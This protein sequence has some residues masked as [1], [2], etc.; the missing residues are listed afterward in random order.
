[1]S[2][3]ETLEFEFTPADACGFIPVKLS[4]S[5]GAVLQCYPRLALPF[6]PT[7]PTVFSAQPGSLPYRGA[8]GDRL[9]L[10]DVT[11]N[12]EV[13]RLRVRAIGS[14]VKPPSN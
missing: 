8:L 12:S 7:A 14:K 3:Q 11:E 6:P 9:H 13:H 5:H 1:M 4:Q 10:A 2:V